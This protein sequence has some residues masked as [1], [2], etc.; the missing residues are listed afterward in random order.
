[1][2][3]DII[4]ILNA[5]AFAAE[6]HSHQRRKDAQASP[7]INHPLALAQTIR[8]CRLNRRVDALEQS[9]PPERSLA[10][11]AWLGWQITD[12]ERAQLAEEEAQRK[13]I[14]WNRRPDAR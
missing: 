3:N 1:M 12:E 10:I 8:W 11:K 7:Y 4:L 14:D 5:A 9:D 13:P 6:K 2:D